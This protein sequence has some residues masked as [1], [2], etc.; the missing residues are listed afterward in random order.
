MM[1]SALP[2]RPPVYC[3]NPT[4]G[5][6]LGPGSHDLCLGNVKASRESRRVKAAETPSPEFRA[7][8]LR[9]LLPV[10]KADPCDGLGGMSG[11]HGIPDLLTLRREKPPG[12]PLCSFVSCVERFDDAEILRL[13]L[14]HARPRTTA[15]RLPLDTGLAPQ[16]PVWEWDS[17]GISRV[18]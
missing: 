9:P 10:R 11:V 6:D 16:T 5:P 12:Q 2:Q 8:K 18:G 1:A 14:E 3:N 7:G 17:S 13:G 15:L 4:V